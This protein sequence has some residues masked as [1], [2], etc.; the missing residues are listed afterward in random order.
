MMAIPK[1]SEHYADKIAKLLAKAESTTPEEAE[2]LVAK[3]QELMTAYAVS[4]AM[5]DSVR[6][7]ERDEIGQDEYVGIFRAAVADIGRAVARANGW[8]PKDTPFCDGCQCGLAKDVVQWV[9]RNA[10]RESA[11]LTPSP[12]WSVN[13]HALS[14]FVAERA[15]VPDATVKSW[16]EEAQNEEED[17]L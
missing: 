1:T 15:D 6:G 17:T 16:I 9:A 10:E 8:R 11:F 3:A 14:K 7:I 13:A 2:S 4:E 12:S 5:I